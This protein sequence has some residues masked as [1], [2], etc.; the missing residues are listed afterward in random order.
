MAKKTIGAE[1]IEAMED[2]LACINGKRAGHR[3]YASGKPA[4]SVRSDR[5]RVAA[6]SSS[7]SRRRIDR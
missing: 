3:V 5:P 6:R 2:A 1:L 7:K 4:I